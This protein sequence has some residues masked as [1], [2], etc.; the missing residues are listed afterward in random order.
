MQ[1][2]WGLLLWPASEEEAGVYR[3]LRFLIGL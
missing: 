1:V 3:G 2:A